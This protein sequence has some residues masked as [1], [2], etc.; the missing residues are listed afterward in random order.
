MKRTLQ[1]GTKRNLQEKAPVE[2]LIV[3]KKFPSGSPNEKT[4]AFATVFFYNHLGGGELKRT[5]QIGTKRNLQEK[6][7]VEL[8]IVEKKFPSGSPNEKTVAF[9]TVFFVISAVFC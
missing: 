6:A 7:P 3:E 5:L 2:L 1:I 9:A 8:L 4:V